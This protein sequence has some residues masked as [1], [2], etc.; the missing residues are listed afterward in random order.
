[1]S[2]RFQFSLRGLLLAMLLVLASLAA[3]VWLCRYGN[4]LSVSRAVA[5]DPATFRVRFFCPF[6]ENAD[7]T[8]AGLIASTDTGR[9]CTGPALIYLRRSWPFLE[10]E[11]TMTLA[12]PDRYSV[13]ATCP[14][15]GGERVF[16]DFD[17]A[18]AASQ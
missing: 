5:G 18:P 2:R 10:G 1:M 12:N 6:S 14:S 4:S 3:Y 9:H 11:G 16:C 8:F 7:G 13:R 15:L 17:V